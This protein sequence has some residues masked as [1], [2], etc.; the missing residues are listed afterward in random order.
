MLPTGPNVS[1]A[2]LTALEEAALTIGQ[3]TDK[4]KNGDSLVIVLLT[5]MDGSL[6][7][8][9]DLTGSFADENASAR[10][11]TAKWA[12][13]CGKIS[14]G[15]ME[16]CAHGGG[17]GGRPSYLARSTIIPCSYSVKVFSDSDRRCT[18]CEMMLQ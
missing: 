1:A 15:D 9:T 4:E 12:D 13:P 16:A 7:R 3:H 10:R 14:C 5:A 17:R 11:V 2:N 8:K 18:A 6:A